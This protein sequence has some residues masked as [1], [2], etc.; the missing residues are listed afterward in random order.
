MPVPARPGHPQGAPLRLPLGRCPCRW[1]GVR[2]LFP[3]VGA[4][5]VVALRVM[6]GT[7]P[8]DASS[9]S[10]WA[11]T[12]GAPTFA[13]GAVPVPLGRCPWF[14]SDHRGIPCGCPPGDGRNPTTDA[15]SCSAWA[16]TRGA[17]TFA[18]GA[19]PVPL[20]RCPWFISDHRGIPCGCPPGD[21]R[22]P[23]TDASSCSAWAP[24]RGAPTL[25]AGAVSVPLGRCPWFIS[26]RRG[27]PCGCP[28]STDRMWRKGRPM[29][30][31]VR[32]IA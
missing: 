24:T 9:C 13:A 7:A 17:P 16:P 31:A 2:G 26:D 14:I 8:T 6:V 20:G 12:R 3:I 19:V 22:N 21:G 30:P 28:G 5:L 1:G 23:T 32:S 4:S 10:A 18:A 25:V 15:S 29:R 27:I 11:P